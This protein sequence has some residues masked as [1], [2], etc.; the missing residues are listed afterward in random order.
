MPEVTL[1]EVLKQARAL[2]EQG[3]CQGVLAK[4]HGL[5][6]D[7]EDPDADGRCLIGAL[8][9]AALQ[10]TRTTAPRREPQH[11]FCKRMNRQH[12]HA[13]QLF[14]GVRE[15]IKRQ[16]RAQSDH[17]IDYTDLPRWNDAPERTQAEVIAL[18]EGAIACLK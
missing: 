17:A 3:W 2:L 4:K 7:R 11:Q 13:T 15:L 1:V 6:V 8:G 14:D 10:L 5:L 12:A 16:L 9:Y 18:V